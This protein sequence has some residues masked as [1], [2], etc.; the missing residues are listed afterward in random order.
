MK[1]EFVHHIHD[2]EFHGRELW[3]T[4]RDAGYAHEYTEELAQKIGR[5]FYEVTLSCVLDTETGRVEIVRATT[6]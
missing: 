4:I 1:I 6:N 5:P 3:A 2:D